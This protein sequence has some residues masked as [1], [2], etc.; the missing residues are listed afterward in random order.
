MLQFIK[1]VCSHKSV[2]VLI[3]IL[4]IYLHSGSPLTNKATYKLVCT[5]NLIPEIKKT[6]PC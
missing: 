1:L 2:C 3:N 6:Y 5:F 4:N